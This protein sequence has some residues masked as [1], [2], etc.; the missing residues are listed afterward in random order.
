MCCLKIDMVNAFNNCSYHRFYTVFI[1]NF[2][3]GLHGSSGV[4]IVKESFCL[5]DHTIYSHGGVQQGDL[6]GPLLFCSW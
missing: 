5:G 4:T 1:R 6:L 3:R 2:S